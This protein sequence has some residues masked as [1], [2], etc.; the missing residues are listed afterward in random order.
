MC[1]KTEKMFLQDINSY[2]KIIWTLQ[3]IYGCPDYQ[4]N[5]NGNMGYTDEDKVLVISP[6]VFEK[7]RNSKEIHTQIKAQVY[8]CNKIMSIIKNY[9]KHNQPY[10]GA[11]TCQFS[12]DIIASIANNTTINWTIIDYLQP[13]CE[14]I[15][16]MTLKRHKHHNQ[17]Y[18]ITFGP[19][20][21]YLFVN[22]KK[23]TYH[24]YSKQSE[25]TTNNVT[26]CVCDWVPPLSEYECD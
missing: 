21:F 17:L 6:D 22:H 5:F 23:K 20:Q 24:I 10:E 12:A 8:L 13:I 7:R 18:K 1:G 4:T 2:K 14:Y 15:S 9:R 3:S 16:Q 25:S 19:S 11:E 26:Q